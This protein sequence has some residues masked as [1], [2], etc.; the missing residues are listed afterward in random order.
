[1]L[2]KSNGTDYEQ[3]PLGTHVARCV[4]LIDIGTQDSEYE[5]KK[6][7]RRQVVVSWELC[8]ELMTEGDFAGQPFLMSKFFTQSLNEKAK[9]RQWLITWRGRDFTAE[10]LEGFDA[11]NI[12]GVPCLISVTASETTGK[13]IVS[14]VMKLTKGIKPPAQIT[15]TVFFSLE[16]DEFD[17]AVYE[18]LSDGL[19]KMINLSPEWA[20]LSAAP[21]AKPA[22]AQS[23]DPAEWPDDEE[24]CD[25]M[26]DF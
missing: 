2:W 19:K 23:D 12:L 26:P 21:S 1:M 25:G 24:D 11:K 9:L 20:A 5:G 22:P 13:S 4:R 17:A 10:E 16:P 15:P 6:S 7:S 8:E 18:G 3:A 14:G